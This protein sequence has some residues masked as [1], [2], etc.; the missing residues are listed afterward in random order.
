MLSW[1]QRAGGIKEN[2][3]GRNEHAHKKDSESPMHQCTIDYIVFKREKPKLPRPESLS[4]DAASRLMNAPPIP[5][6]NTGELQTE[7]K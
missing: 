3:Y 4:I 6:I 7:V 5:T 1:L 2:T